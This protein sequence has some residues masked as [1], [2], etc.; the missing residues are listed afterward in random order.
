MTAEATPTPRVDETRDER[1]AR[2]QAALQLTGD[3]LDTLTLT[4]LRLGNSAMSRQAGR[5]IDLAHAITTPTEDRWDALAYCAWLQAK[6]HNHSAKLGE[7]LALTAGELMA[8]VTP[9]PPALP[10]ED[11]EDQDETVTLQDVEDAARLDPTD[12]TP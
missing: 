7:Y 12:P 6:R 3:P 5:S 8:V 10:A 11:T 4:E 2:L 9:P 1:L